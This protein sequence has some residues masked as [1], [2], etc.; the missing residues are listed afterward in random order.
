[1]MKARDVAAGEMDWRKGGKF[2][3]SAE[4]CILQSFRYFLLC[5]FSYKSE[6][7]PFFLSYVACLKLICISP[8][9]LFMYSE[10]YLFLGN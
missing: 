5:V 8:V 3:L 1:M 10:N 4:Y 9:V 6:F 7:L 2:C